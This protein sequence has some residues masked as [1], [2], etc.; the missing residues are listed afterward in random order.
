MLTEIKLLSV[1]R[2]V[3]ERF[4]SYKKIARRNYFDVGTFF[5]LWQRSKMYQW[6]QTLD[7]QKKYRLIN[8]TLK[9]QE[10]ILKVWMCTSLINIMYQLKLNLESPWFIFEP[11]QQSRFRSI[12]QNRWHGTN[13][14]NNKHKIPLKENL[15]IDFLL[16]TETITT[17]YFVENIFVTLVNL[18]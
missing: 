14:N 10:Y 11:F 15:N 1:S 13:I 2:T 4:K 17:Y 16:L 7:S 12:F 18:S 9:H 3:N 6:E 8:M 5:L